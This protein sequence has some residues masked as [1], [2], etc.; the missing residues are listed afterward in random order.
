MYL[1]VAFRISELESTDNLSSPYN[2]ILKHL[3][4]LGNR[5]VATLNKLSV[6]KISPVF[7][8]RLAVQRKV[9]RVLNTVV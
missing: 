9:C 3:K 2:I 5:T 7:I 8:V 1:K 4:D 6:K